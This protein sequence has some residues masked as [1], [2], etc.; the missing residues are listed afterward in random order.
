MSKKIR[1]KIF[2]KYDGRCAYTGK[3]LDDKWQ[4][5]HIEPVFYYTMFRLQGDAHHESNLVP[6]LRIINHYKRAK[7][8]GE[9]RQYMMTFHNRIA[10]LP[11]NPKVAKSIKRKAY[12]LEVA[13]LFG[14]EPDKPFSGIFYF[15]TIDKTKQP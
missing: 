11:H 13:S 5:D 10:K 1:Q 3:P 7:G 6:A 4:V 12:M 15:E 2:E 14:I 8:L 9:F